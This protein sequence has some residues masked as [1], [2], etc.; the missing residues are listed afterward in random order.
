MSRL[1]SALL[2]C[3]V[4]LPTQSQQATVS[5][6]VSD[7]QSGAIPGVEVIAVNLATNVT[8]RAVSNDA[9]FY[10]LRALPIGAYRLT[11]EKAGFRKAL[12]EDLVLTTGQS[13]ELDLRLEVGSVAETVSV[14]AQTSLIETRTSDSSQL[15]E[16]RSVEDIPLGD[17]RTMN[18]LRLTGAAVFVN[19]DSGSKPNFSVAGGR[20]QS[21]NFYMDGGTIQNM[22]LGIGQ[23]DTDPPV[24]TVAEVKVL[25]NSFAAEYGGS[26]GGVVVATTKS[27]TNQLRGSAYE[28]LRNQVLDARNFFAPVVDG[29]KQRAPLRYNVFG[30]T[31]GGPV[32][33]PKI[34]N[35]RDKAFFYFAYEGSRRRDGFTDQFGVPTTEQR[36]GD[37]SRTFAANGTVVPI[38]DPKTTRTEAGRSV[39]NPYPGNV[40]PAT[41]IDKV[42]AALMPFY[43][44]P[45][46]PP[47][48]IT[49]A[50]NFRTNYVM[51]LTRD[52]YLVKG[53][54]NVTDKDR[55]SLRYL[56]N[57]DDRTSTTVMTN[58]AADTRAPAIRHQNFFYGT[59][60]R[61]FSPSMINE[62]RFTYGNRVNHEASFGL[63][64]SW[65][66]K[67]GL[68]GV[69]ENAF[70]Q[71]NI[72]GFRALGAA[73]QERRQF[74]I[75]Q[76]QWID[77]LSWTRGRHTFK[78]GVEARPSYNYE[79]NYPTVSGS[80]TTGLQATSMPGVATSGYGLASTLAGAVT[81]F[82][83]RQTEALNRQSW[84]VSWFAQ[85]DWQ[86][87][88]N[89]TL[90]LGLRWETDTPIRDIKDR[91]NGFDMRAINPVSGTP[92]VVKFM[93]QNGFR[94]TPYDTDWNNFGPRAGLAWK[95]FSDGK[96]VVR[97]G[98]G[99]FYAHPFDRGAPTSAS[100][101]YEISAAINSP[102]N[103]ITIPFYLQN[104][105]PGYNPTKPPLD[106]S[107]GAVR[108]GQN[109]TT[110][111][112]FY[113][114]NRRT[115]YS[116]QWNF[117]IQREIST[118]LVEASYLGNQSR[119]LASANFPINQVRPGIL[120]AT[121]TQRDRP[122][123]QFSNVTLVAPSFGNSN[124]HALVIKSE[125]RFSKG[126]S[127]LANYTWSK[128]LND[129]DEGGATL[130]A[131]NTYSNGYDR[132]AD[133]G[134]SENDIPHRF[135]LSGVYELPFGKGR[136]FAQSRLSDAV[137]G[138]WSFGGVFTVQSGPAYTVVTEVN[139]VY[140]AAGALRADVLRNPNLPAE[141]RTLARWFDTEAFA[142]PAAAMF[143]NQGVNILRGDGMTNVDFSFMKGWRLPG[144][145][146]KI[147]FRSEFFNAFNHPDFG[148]PGRTFGGPGFG[149]V[150]GVRAARSIQLGLRLVY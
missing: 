8:Y 112:T 10:S 27:G 48:N 41:Q 141:S 150:S 79:E 14:T 96:T 7:P 109:G 139:T 58:A 66:S 26:A 111:V 16:A 117:G 140:S 77:N 68:K 122:Y 70:P 45:N 1:V 95:P 11:A 51:G 92:G 22:R 145:G 29:E 104:G 85:D 138:G 105:V 83:A 113:E 18:I 125:K 4:L 25:A 121:S 89:L 31:V 67:I 44:M 12:R 62:F 52:A 54:L 73:S 82:A 90:N 46:R 50:N 99:M 37:F 57:S 132:R 76:L 94:T 147:Q 78:F 9:G 65:P 102:D 101:G 32:I 59:Y 23:I 36:A 21:Q 143:G 133:Y 13:L 15:V 43:P 56:Y 124:Y 17:R 91:M 6:T 42:G 114:E 134:P 5:G 64:E 129:A 107:F 81:G 128:F 148:L 98:A 63:G 135:N 120:T 40:I 71:F 20:T 24:E 33:L 49:G 110:A 38:Y 103:G 84:Y 47:D 69:P 118:I 75:E 97:A 119:K 137:L 3:A 115:G 127:F 116:M 34:Y 86:I 74:P 108:V 53:D 123:P 126:F 142:Q 55:L 88:N 144:E 146:R 131:E 30:A 60:T 130:G 80:F 2:V 61:V 28:Y 72:P 106:D 39:R 93:G 19:Y 149:L 35:G 136:R 87:R 100:L